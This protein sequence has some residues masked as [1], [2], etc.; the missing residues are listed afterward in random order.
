MS[1]YPSCLN[2]SLFMLKKIGVPV[3]APIG[4]V[5]LLDD[6]EPSSTLQCSIASIP[7]QYL[8]CILLRRDQHV[9][10]I[11][12]CWI[13]L[14]MN[15]L[16]CSSQNSSHRH[17]FCGVRHPPAREAIVAGTFARSA[18]C[19]AMPHRLNL[20]R[21][22]CTR[23]LIACVC[24]CMFALY[25]WVVITRCFRSSIHLRCASCSCVSDQFAGGL[26]TSKAGCS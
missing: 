7:S 17:F 20:E 8:C 25:F 1:S 18:V 11:A 6:R 24:T 26:M 12:S 9:L 22:P 15:E 14:D 4:E 21:L 16:L 19:F 5:P 13:H 3:T 2:S 10:S 23:W